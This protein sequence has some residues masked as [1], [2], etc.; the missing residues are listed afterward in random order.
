MILNYLPTLLIFCGAAVF[1]FY[2]SFHPFLLLFILLTIV[3]TLKK[4]MAEMTSSF[5]PFA[6]GLLLPLIK[7]AA[8]WDSTDFKGRAA[9]LLLMVTL[10]SVYL[11]FKKL[12]L[13][14]KFL[15]FFSSLSN[16]KKGVLIFICAE[17]VFI[18]SSWQLTKKGVAL[19]GDEPH[20]Y[21]I[22]YSLARDFDLDVSNQYLEKQFKEFLQ[23]ENLGIHGYFGKKKG[24]IFSMHLFGLPLTLLPVYWLKLSAPPL[25]MVLRSYMGLFG[26]LS[27]VLLF[28][29]LGHFF[30]RQKL[31]LFLTV[32]FITGAPTFF[33]SIHLYP[34]IQVLMFQL[35]TLYI[36]FC[37]RLNYKL[38]YFLASLPLAI[39]LFWG[40]KFSLPAY[41]FLAGILIYLLKK[42]LFS[43]AMLF[44]IFPLIFQALFYLFLYNAYGTFSPSAIYTGIMNGE[45]QKA[46]LYTIFHT[47]TL[48]MRLETLLDYF[49]DQRDGIFFYNPVFFLIGGGLLLALKNFKK[50]RTLFVGLIPA[51]LYVLNYAF[52]THRGG[53]SPQARPLTAAIYLLFAL[54]AIY[55]SE[56]ENELLR[57]FLPL[58]LIVASLIS[59]FQLGHPETIYQPTTHDFPFRSGLLF[60][61]WSNLQISF[62]SVLPS[63]AKID[64][65]SYL[66][67]YLWIIFFVIFSL[68]SII[69]IRLTAF[70]QNLISA[71]LIL[72]FLI[73][74]V[75]VPSPDI[76]NPIKINKSGALPHQILGISSWPAQANE[77][78]FFFEKNDFR[79]FAIATRKPAAIFVV[80]VESE[81]EINNQTFLTVKNFDCRLAR[82]R[83]LNA[84]KQ[85]YYLLQTS[86]KQYKGNFIYQ[87]E[88]EFQTP[89]QLQKPL[90]IQI[91]PLR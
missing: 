42:H 35:L 16:L 62:S 71:L 1:F 23:T 66:P 33:H 75:L 46:F 90:K 89:Q 67:N 14:N 6:C 88:I 41:L 86:G 82:M 73:I 55:I 39:T 58:F 78:A 9:N 85:N 44:L 36:I 84:P 68:F 32:I 40:V 56:T 79:R 29:L 38:R 28:F 25:Y 45:Q 4:K 48:K 10:I 51:A 3:F 11:I 76:F 87:F 77:R 21:L 61:Y 49:F 18:F 72:S 19:S 83:L 24:T 54:C 37:T 27:A 65:D 64:N 22:T 26:A 31:A 12:N 69:K 43:S 53:F 17:S 60:Q 15:T 63:F 91:F 52:L 81:A 74:F 7:R 20:Y 47:I 2:L 50:Y 57:K 70:R 13:L 5:L 30:R 8:Y 80:Q 59:L 34:D